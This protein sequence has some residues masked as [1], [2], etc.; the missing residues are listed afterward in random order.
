MTFDEGLEGITALSQWYSDHQ[1]SRNE[2]TTRLRLIDTIFF[3]CLGW[4][5]DEVILEEAHNKEYADYTFQAPRRVLIVEAKREGDYFVLPAGQT[6]LEMPIPALMK[7]YANVAA[8]LEQA[9][10]YCQ[11]RGVPFGAIC[12]GHQLIA[13]IAS[14]N[15]AIPPLEGRALVFGSTDEMQTRFLDLWNALSK[16]GIL[17]K[18]LL[19]RLTTGAPAIPRKLSA[20]VNPYPGVIERNVVQNDLQILSDVILEDI[21]PSPELESTF[22]E[23]CYAQSGALSQF[24]LAS[25]QILEARYASMFVNSDAPTPLVVPAVHKGGLSSELLS[26][27][28]ARRPILLLVGV[29]KT[30]FIRN[31]IKVEAA[32]IFENAIGLHLNLG[33]QAALATD[34]RLYVLDEIEKQLRENFD[35]DIN[36]ATF[37]RGT[38]DLDLKRFSSSIY[39]ELQATSPDLYRQKELEE[40][41]RLTAN[42]S[43]HMRRSLEH[44]V[45]AR[46]RQVVLFLDNADQRD[47]PTQEAAFL[48]AQEI[49]QQWPA[50]VFVSLRPETFNRSQRMGALTG[51]HAKAFTISPPR[52]DQV[53]LKRLNFA[54]K[55]T[56]GKIPVPRLQHVGIKLESLTS[57]I[58]ILLHSLQRDARLFEFL[59]N[60]SGGNVRSALALLTTFIGSGHVNTRK[61]LEVEAT[62][63]RYQ[64]PPHEFIRAV[65]YGD[66]VHFDPSRSAIANMFDIS[67]ADG[68]EHFL[69]PLVI[70]V[71]DRSAA[72]RGMDGF[73][74]TS[75]LYD[76]LQGMGFTPDQIDFAVARG[77]DKKLIQT[78]GRQIPADADDM[79]SSMRV[80]PS[81][82][83]HAYRLTSN[84]QYIDAMMIDTPILHDS[85]R[86]KIRSVEDIG[87]RLTRAEVFVKD[88][89]DGMWSSLSALA[90]G[91][92]W[93]EMSESVQQEI[94][95]IRWRL[96]NKP[97]FVRSGR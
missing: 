1:S 60:V 58:T 18:R 8:A 82:L 29:G 71:L 50:L 3:D 91:F 22:L 52:I 46:K 79:P 92:D 75:Y 73:V 77:I 64:I 10:G 55:I 35:T 69:L 26:V 14:R 49:S 67:S 80:T 59:D 31:L 47:E 96:L 4:T 70:G 90:I 19:Y 9:A 17:E 51:Y 76:S 81:G 57:I 28:L 85:V 39:G 95:A 36:R 20:A 93:A 86:E 83:Y 34:L 53:I 61:M 6:R 97:R 88:Y 25:K 27:G 94:Q 11:S 23:E 30:T 12:N 87:D 63:R 21:V 24:S 48:I 84:F 37:V 66:F 7:T 65:M 89:L 56:A 74:E 72:L 62:G 45:R 43:E 32:G 38:Y 40:L 33:S 5:K 78:S 15:D 44:I 41:S 13:F 54:L 2:A 16:S 42:R 68:R